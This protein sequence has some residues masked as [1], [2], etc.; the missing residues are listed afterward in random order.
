[1]TPF[2][3]VSGTGPDLVLL[4]G[5]ASSRRLWRRVVPTLATAFRCWSVD[6]P[7]FG[8]APDLGRRAGDVR[9]YSAWL[10]DFCDAQGI[11]RCGLAGHSMG[12]ALTLQF[13]ADQ[14]DR[15]RAFSAINPVV[16]GRVI[17]RALDLLPQRAR[18]MS[19]SHEFSQTVLGPILARPELDGLRDVIWPL[20]RRIEDF[21]VASG[22][23]LLDTWDL[24]TDFDVRPQ[25]SSVTAPGLIV[26][27]SLDFNVPNSEGLSAAAVLANVTVA[28]FTAGHTI[29]DTYPR[30]VADLLLGF[31]TRVLVDEGA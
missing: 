10:R 29:T 6:L 16:T 26:L 18:W 17:L 8:H 4:H 3:E 30:A 5:W 11:E 12:G 27:G 31:F 22:P 14:P 21:N 25:L 1:M 24:L 15:V 20:Q 28:R 7:G 2:F 9:A 19:W 23:T 13:A